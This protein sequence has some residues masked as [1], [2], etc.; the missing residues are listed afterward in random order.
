MKIVQ[1]IRCDLSEHL[2]AWEASTLER[3]AIIS[4]EKLLENLILMKTKEM[5]YSSPESQRQWHTPTI[6]SCLGVQV[7]RILSSKLFCKETALQWDALSILLSI[8]L[9]G[10]KS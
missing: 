2:M 10:S 3:I 9:L 7:W 1:L 6:P 5:Q 4:P 8:R